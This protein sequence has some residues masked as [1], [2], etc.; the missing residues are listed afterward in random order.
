M[1][2]IDHVTE[3][4]QLRQYAA[5]M[6]QMGGDA[7]TVIATAQLHATLALV[8]QQRIS[9]LIALSAGGHGGSTGLERYGMA[10]LGAMS[11]EEWGA[12]MRPHPEI[13]AALGLTAG[14]EGKNDEG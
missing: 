6:S 3:A 10:A 12:E 8:E 13:A 2:K 11:G 5:E 7:G 9:N 4:M 14:Q 1:S